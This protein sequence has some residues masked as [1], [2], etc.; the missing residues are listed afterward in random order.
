[1]LRQCFGR[2]RIELVLPG[3]E[4]LPSLRCLFNRVRRDDLPER[5]LFAWAVEN[6]DDRKR[7]T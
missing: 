5:R 1:M 2:G 3:H 4:Q 6:H 7:M